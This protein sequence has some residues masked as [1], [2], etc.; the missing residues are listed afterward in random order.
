VHEMSEEKIIQ[1]IKWLS[2]QA[3]QGVA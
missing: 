3:F 1:A 2:L